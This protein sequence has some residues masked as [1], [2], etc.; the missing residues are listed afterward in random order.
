M[1]VLVTGASGFVGSHLTRLLVEKGVEVAI[2]K[3][4]K[5]DLWRLKDL[6]HEIVQLDVDEIERDYVL[7]RYECIVHCATNYGSDQVAFSEIVKDNVLWPLRLLEIGIAHGLNLFI[8]T[9]TFYSK[10]EHL[11]DHLKSYTISKRMFAKA[12]SEIEYEMK[13]VTLRLEH[14]YG[15]QDSP[16]KFVQYIKKNLQD[17]SATIDLTDGKQKRDFVYVEDVAE[18]Y[19]KII[20]NLNLL[21]NYQEFEVGTG[22]SIT[23]KEFVET[24]KYIL[25]NSTTKL[26][27]G[28]L[29]RRSN[30]FL[31]STAQNTAMKQLGWLPKT[32]LKEGLKKT[33][34]HSYV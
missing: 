15:P 26:N 3:R 31:E 34:D 6:L 32:T 10:N 19:L 21:N 9:D 17:N 13:I 23:I 4:P 2:V 1:K 12:L 18:S 11:Y 30:E 22:S 29:K 28:K 14:V 27:W 7:N 20:E 25:G 5:S 33:I 24:F 16:N 8:N